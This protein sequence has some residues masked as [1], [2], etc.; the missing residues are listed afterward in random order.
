MQKE[1]TIKYTLNINEP[2]KGQHGIVYQADL[3]GEMAALL[4]VANILES[5]MESLKEAKKTAKGAKQKKD[6]G[7]TIAIM[8]QGLS[9]A[10]TL[11][12][13]LC[14]NYED[15]IMHMAAQLQLQKEEEHFL[16]QQ[17]GNNHE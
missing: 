11:A 9:A 16:T 6:I 15:F 2:T 7:S 13:S 12:N 1:G 4:I 10:N 14:N 8:S 17:Q 5:K 3:E